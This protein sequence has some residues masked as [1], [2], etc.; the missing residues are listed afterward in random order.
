MHFE[1][2]KNFLE[3]EKIHPLKN[4]FFVPG[5]RIFK[6][7]LKKHAFKRILKNEL[8]FTIKKDHN[9]FIKELGC[10]EHF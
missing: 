1:G 3:K 2:K 9:I 8:G 10:Y 7:E 4:F 5:G 6:S